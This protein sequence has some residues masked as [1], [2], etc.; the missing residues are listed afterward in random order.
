M[1]AHYI[2][3]SWNYRRENDA[4]DHTGKETVVCD[5]SKDATDS[6]RAVGYVEVPAELCAAVLAAC[7]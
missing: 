1:L 2:S 7:R 6:P 5:L 4:D 3:E